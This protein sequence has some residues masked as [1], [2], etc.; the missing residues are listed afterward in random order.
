M[1]VSRSD[2]SRSD[3]VRAVTDLLGADQVDTDEQRLRL[4]SVDRFRKYTSVHGIF[5]GPQP[6]AIVYPTSTDEV[7][8]LLDFAHRELV[9]VVP[10]SGG[11]STEG[12]LETVVDD[13]W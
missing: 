5:E 10:R 13:A 1:V 4:A 7:A 8:A 3:I 12:G 2:L 9:A 11:T 6:A